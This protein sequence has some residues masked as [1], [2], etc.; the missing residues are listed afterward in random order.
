MLL[1]NI[2]ITYAT[3][4][5]AYEFFDA[6]EDE[7][8]KIFSEY[9]SM[10]VEIEE[11][12]EIALITILYMLYGTSPEPQFPVPIDEEDFESLNEDFL[13]TLLSVIIIAQTCHELRKDNLLE[14]LVGEDGKTRYKLTPEGVKVGKALAN[15][16]MPY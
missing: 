5:D 13:D 12:S 1:Q 4:S 10:M 7:I 8:M 9:A 11:D 16:K 3:P 15:E 14:K 2:S 6:H